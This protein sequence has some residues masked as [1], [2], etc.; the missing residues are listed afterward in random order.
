MVEK[1]RGKGEQPRSRRSPRADLN[2]LARYIQELKM[3][4][5]KITFPERK[6]LYRST[7]VV[8][9]FTVAVTLVISLFELIV[10]K[11]FSFIMP[12]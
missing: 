4:W 7:V 10:T 6:E 2:P 1:R 9:M 8:F 12:I 5:N 11:L 3:E